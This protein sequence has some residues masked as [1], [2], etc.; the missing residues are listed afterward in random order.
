MSAK[1]HCGL[2]TFIYDLW[3]QNK[4][5]TRT[6]GGT[7][8]HHVCDPSCISFWDIVRK[9][10]RQIG[11]GENPTPAIAIMSNKSTTK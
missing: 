2:M 3:P 11:A 9:T 10:D 4:S 7:Y 1:T 8:L 5:I 6:H